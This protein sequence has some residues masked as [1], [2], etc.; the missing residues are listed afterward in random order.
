MAIV[1]EARAR[2][3]VVAG[4]VP[5]AIDAEQLGW[6]DELAH[7]R[8]IAATGTSADRQLAVFEDEKAAGATHEAALVAVV[9][10]L[11]RR[12]VGMD[13]QRPDPRMLAVH[14]PA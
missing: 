8:T 9:D 5:V 7:L 2:G 13:V 6:Q 4:H 3:A 1:K 14:R 12:T 10:D 11:R